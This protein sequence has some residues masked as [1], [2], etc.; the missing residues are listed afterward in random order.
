[1]RAAIVVL[2]LLLANALVA[3]E[4]PGGNA[5]AGAPAVAVP[6]TAAGKLLEEWLTALNAADGEALRKFAETR[7]TPEARGGRSPAAIAEGQFGSRQSSGGFDVAAIE[8]S[9]ADRLVVILRSRGVFTRYNR[10]SLKL[11]EPDRP[12]IAERRVAPAPPPAGANDGRKPAAEFAKEVERKLEKLTADG[13]FSGAALIAKDGV[14][15]W[16][17]AFGL[18]DREKNA[19]AT[20][21]TRFRLGSMNKMFTSVAIAQ[22]VEAGKLKF[23]D[24]LATVLP[25]YPNKEVAQK[26]TIDQ[27][28]THTSGLGNI[29]GPKFFETKDRLH[30]ISDYLPLFVD[31]PLAFEPGQRWSYSNA[32]F[33]VLGLIIE[34]LSGQS[35]YDYV[36]QHI[37]APAGMTATSSV[38]KTERR[39]D[40]AVGYMRDPAGK[41]VPNWETMP[42]RG[43]SAGGGESTVGDLMR[44]AEALRSHKLLSR[45][46]TELITTGKVEDQPGGTSKYAYGFSERISN[47]RRIV[48]H[49]GGAPGM[50]ADLSILWNEGYS[51]VVLANLDPTVAQ[52]AAAYIADRLL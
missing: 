6:Q 52:D 17:R 9:S 45:E 46:T 4:K 21:E 38:P 42:Y 22:L 19:P 2:L 36:E 48:G 41:L 44:F 3:A 14:A 49:N 43:M 27:L 12:L 31:A 51:V 16:Q 20:L 7:Y 47:G 28:L 35:Y 15:V 13:Q 37:F 18:R 39:E 32:G 34:K 29:F 26:I 8:E 25:D 40:I 5:A 33:I 11:A 50:N 10:L 23:S 24:T 30:T 1:M